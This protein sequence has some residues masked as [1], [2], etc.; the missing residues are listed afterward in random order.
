MDKIFRMLAR[1]SL[2][3]YP[4]WLQDKLRN[5]MDKI[6]SCRIAVKFGYV[7]GQ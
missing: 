3:V 1:I 7:G 5:Q 2:V 4:L 6:Y